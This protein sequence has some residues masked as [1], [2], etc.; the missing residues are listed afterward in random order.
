M[1]VS[2]SWSLGVVAAT[3]SVEWI[4]RPATLSLMSLVLLGLNAPGMTR[5][6]IGI[7]Y[8]PYSNDLLEGWSALHETLELGLI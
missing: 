3:C 7:L 6:S 1:V 5:Q 2:Q 4:P 8:E